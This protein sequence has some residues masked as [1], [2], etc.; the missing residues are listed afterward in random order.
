MKLL[1]LQK[2]LS[3]IYQLIIVYYQ[4]YFVNLFKAI[5]VEKASFFCYWKLKLDN[6]IKFVFLILIDADI[7]KRNRH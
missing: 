1:L 2:Q 5:F 6:G 3:V 4:W 7:A